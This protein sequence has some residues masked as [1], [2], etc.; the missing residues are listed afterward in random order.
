M[1][2]IG[3]LGRNAQAML[4]G[5]TAQSLQMSVRTFAPTPGPADILSDSMSG[6][7]EDPAALQA[8]LTDLTMVTTAG[9]DVPVTTLDACIEVCTTMPTGLS[10]YC[11]QDRAKL[12]EM[13]TK[14]HIP[15]AKTLPVGSASDV[16]RA[17]GTI[18]LPLLLVSNQRQNEEH[19]PHVLS[20][21]EEALQA[22][23]A[24]T[25]DDM[26]IEQFS[27][28]EQEIACL[29]VRSTNGTIALYPFTE[30]VRSR[31]LIQDLIAPATVHPTAAEEM[32]KAAR[33]MLETLGHVG[34]MCITFFVRGNNILLDS[35][36]PTVHPAG[37]WTIENSKTSQ[38]EN[39]IRALLGEEPRP[40]DITGSC[41]VSRLFGHVPPALKKL[42]GGNMMVHVYN[43]GTEAEDVSVGHVTMMNTERPDF[44]D[45]WQK[46]SAALDR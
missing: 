28:P 42:D 8:F 35:L 19:S 4:L 13:C 27:N 10:Q 18:G 43:P 29:A 38:Y 24:R 32:T 25:S 3:I 40:C 33:A 30:L 15:C 41:R 17:V 31:G 34:V 2:R 21:L 12:K 37:L 5:Q 7:F 20:R 16:E 39:H 23:E 9:I 1:S 22:F 44:A 6:S 36:T 45:Q 26:F 14:L 46:L 11:A